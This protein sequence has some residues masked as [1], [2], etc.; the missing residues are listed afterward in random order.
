[1]KRIMTRV[2]C[3]ILFCGTFLAGCASNHTVSQSSETPRLDVVGAW[4][5]SSERTKGIL[6]GGATGAV[7]GG[8]TSGAGLLPAAA[9]G[10]IL[11]GAFGAYLDSSRTLADSLESHGANVMILGDQ[12]KIVLSANDLFQQNS[13]NFRASAPS[14]LNAVSH[15]VSQYQNRQVMV[16]AF[17]DPSESS[18]T[19]LALTTAQADAIARWLWQSGINTRLLYA[20]GYGNTR[21]VAKPCGNHW[22]GNNRIEITLAKLP[23]DAG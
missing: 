17:T 2:C 16:S 18:S 19:S 5:G 21:P 13:A 22:A 14:A 23:E 4:Q 1:M 8:M 20:A 7:A 9:G 3:F 12:I 11:G 15:F 10:A 6:I